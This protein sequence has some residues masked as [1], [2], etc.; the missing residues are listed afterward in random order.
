MHPATIIIILR[1]INITS[2]SSDI[3]RLFI[4]NINVSSNSIVVD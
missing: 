2:N 3:S 4:I 1:L